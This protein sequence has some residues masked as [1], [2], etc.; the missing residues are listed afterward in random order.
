MSDLTPAE[1]SPLGLKIA[2]LDDGT[3]FDD[4]TGEILD[5]SSPAVI[6]AMEASPPP[7]AV[8]IRFEVTDDDGAEWALEK[9]QDID[10]E[11]AYLE[12]KKAAVVANIDA[13]IRVRERR[14]QWWF[15]RFAGS[16]AEHAKRR[17]AETRAKGK[18]YQLQ[19]GK[20]SFRES[21]G[22]REILLADEAAAFVDRWR[23]DLIRR[24]V[25]PVRL[26]DIDAAIKAAVEETDDPVYL[27]PSFLLV[28]GKKTSTKIE[29]GIKQALEGPK[30]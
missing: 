23:P 15:L 8:S 10:G 17:L 7:A 27:R 21:A 22:R 24:T 2:Y 4:Q 28:E 29:T 30:K 5:P 11:L 18:T 26:S 6:L 19:N 13:L 12:A 14:R 1:A 16:M 3:P 9:L 20:V 25:L